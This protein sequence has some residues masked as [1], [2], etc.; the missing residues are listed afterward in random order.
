MARNTQLVLLLG[1]SLI[2]RPLF[3]QA[4]PQPAPSTSTSAAPAVAPTSEPTPPVAPAPTPSPAPAAPDAAAPS[5]P[6]APPLPSASAPAPPTAP[7]PA[8]I[9]T[10]DPTHS[11]VH[12]GSSHAGTWLELKSSVDQGDWQRVCPAPC[13]RSL[14]V[15]GALARV[16]APGMTP[17]NPFRIEPGAG[18][19]FVRVDGGSAKARSIGILG[20]FIGIPT[21][22]RWRA[23]ITKL[24][25]RWR[26]G[27]WSASPTRR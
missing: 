5:A 2:S 13:D 25:S 3:A 4:A 21:A 18:T 27:C 7:S 16:S 24:T 9:V 26:S 23:S 14:M 17:S 10:R 12:L 6:V 22:V 19:A 15:S 8:P 11:L 1:T 20:L